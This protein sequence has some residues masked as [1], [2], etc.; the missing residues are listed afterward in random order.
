MGTNNSVISIKEYGKV[1]F[2]FKEIMDKKDITRYKLTKLTGIRFEVA[3]RFYN[4]NIERLDIDILSR[5]LFVLD[6][7]ISDV[8]KYER[9]I[10]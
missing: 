3:D 4:G 9:T 8:I 5:I 2:H 1:T 10:E 7:D 6:C